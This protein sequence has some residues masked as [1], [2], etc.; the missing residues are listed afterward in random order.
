MDPRLGR[1]FETLAHAAER[2]G[3]SVR[4]LRRRINDG[5][6]TAYRTGRLIR[7]EPSDVDGL[8]VKVPHFS[9]QSEW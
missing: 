7:V 9:G 3:V 4:T 6:L 5:E 2:T 8:L 1:S